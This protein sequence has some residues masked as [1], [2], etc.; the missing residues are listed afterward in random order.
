MDAVL[1]ILPGS[2]ATNSSSAAKYQSHQTAEPRSLLLV[3]AIP[4]ME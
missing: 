3:L 4:V 2:P 1:I